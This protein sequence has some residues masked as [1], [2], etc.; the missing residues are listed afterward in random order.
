MTQ[1]FQLQD[2]ESLYGLGQYNEPYWDYRGRD[3]LMVQTNIG[4]VLPFMLSS[5]RYGLLWDVYS[6]MRFTD[7]AQG[8]R[9]W[10]D[11]APAGA[12]YY[13]V[14][15]QDMDAVMRGLRTLTGAA[16]M[17]PRRP[18]ASSRARSAT[19]RRPRCSTS[20]N[21]SAPTTSRSTTSCRTGST[22]A[23]PPTAPGAA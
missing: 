20:S 10:A 6:K 11:S 14:A 9:F 1:G 3:V 2:G 16:T 8:A 22:G 13:L 5:Q 19:R 21:A 17:L 18:S 4:I 15:G 12:D 23:A 7:D